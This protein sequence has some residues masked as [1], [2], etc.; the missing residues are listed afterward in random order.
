MP[1]TLGPPTRAAAIFSPW[2]IQS[3]ILANLPDE[4]KGV[5]TLTRTSAH[6]I[7][8]NWRPRVNADADA[9]ALDV[10]P[11]D[12]LEVLARR[13]SL[14]YGGCLLCRVLETRKGRPAGFLQWV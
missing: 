11:L 1:D 13:A 10:K 3:Y 6:L 2:L 9:E 5:V 8:Q 12:Q 7:W 4:S 14:T